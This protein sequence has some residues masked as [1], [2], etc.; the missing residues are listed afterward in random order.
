MINGFLIV[1]IAL[2][3]VILINVV[4]IISFARGSTRAQLNVFNRLATRLRNP[5]EPQNSAAAELRQR[6]AGLQSSPGTEDEADE[7]G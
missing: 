4:L 3:L 2:A 5:L 7:Q 6:V 1:A